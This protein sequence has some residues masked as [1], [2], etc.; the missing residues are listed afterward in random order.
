MLGSFLKNST[1]GYF[2]KRGRFNFKLARARWLVTG[3]SRLILLAA[4]CT[5][6]APFTGPKGDSSSSRNNGAC[7]ANELRENFNPTRNV[8]SGAQLKNNSCCFI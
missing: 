5:T 6:Y 7:G 1:A 2:R 3:W 8:R 4:V